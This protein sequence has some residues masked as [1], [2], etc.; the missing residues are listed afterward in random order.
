MPPTGRVALITG[1]SR[2][3]GRGCA[4][5]LAASGHHVVINFRS[6]GD[7]ARAVADQCRAHGIEAIT[8]QCDVRDRNAVDAMFAKTIEQFKR[9]DV[10]VSNAAD[11]IRKPFVDL[12]VEDIAYTLDVSLWGVIHTAQAAA[13]AL[14]KQGT[15]GSMIFIST[16]HVPFPYA[17][18]APYNMAKAAGHALAMTLATELVQDR[19][20]VNIVEPGWIDTPGERKWTSDAEMA[21]AGKRLPWKRLG[22]IQD[23]GDTVAYLASDKADYITGSVFRVDGGFTLPVPA[24]E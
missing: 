22:T 7:E 2:G 21:E 23:I 8:F 9:L 13:R 17:T 3:I 24:N 20:R 4:E 10:F 12:T 1:A 5:A 18:A 11:S 19:I 16:V 15:G 6:H 14:V